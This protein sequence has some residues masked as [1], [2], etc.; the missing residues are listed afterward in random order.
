MN[1]LSSYAHWLHL[2]WPAG[3]PEPLP[4][5]GPD[6]LTAVNGIRIAGDLLGIP[7][8]KFAVDSGAKAVQAFIDEQA[9]K[10][11]CK[12]HPDTYDLAIIGGGVS[13]LS[14][15]LAAHK[16]GLKFVIYEAVEPFATI[17]NFTNGKPIYTYPKTFQPAGDIKL[18][19]TRK[20]ALLAELQQQAVAANIQF[21]LRKVD[22]IV[23]DDKR[24][25]L[26]F[27]DAHG[28]AYAKRVLVC[29]GRNGEHSTLNVP[30]EG[31]AKVHNRLFDPGDYQG[32]KVLVVGGGDSALETAISLCEAGA[33]VTLSYRGSEFS[34]PKPD[35]IVKAQTLLGNAIWFNSQVIEITKD[36]V[37]LSRADSGLEM[38]SNE[39]VFVMIGRKAPI[40]FLKRLG[41]PAR[42]QWSAGKF[43][44]LLLVLLLVALIYSGKSGSG[45]VFS[46][47]FNHSLTP[48]NIDFSRWPDDQAWLRALQPALASCGFYYELAYTLVIGLFGWRRITRTPT[49]YVKRQ[50]LTLFAIQA[51]PLFLLPFVLLPIAGEFG[52]FDSGVAAWLADQLFPYSEQTG[53]REYWRSV[54]FILAWPLFIANVFTEQPNYAW[55]AIGFGQTFVL[56][57]WLVYRYGKGAYCGW[58]CSCGALAETLGDAQRTKMPHGSIWNKLNMAGQA[59][60]AVAILLLLLRIAAWALV[61]SPVGETLADIFTQATYQFKLF[62]IPLNYAEVVDY[63][64]AGILGLGLY[65][66]FSGRTWCRFFCPLAALMH[67]YARFSQFRIFADKDKCISCNICTTVCHQGI[68]VMAFA[69]KGK[70]MEDPQCVRCSACV[71]GCPTGTFNVRTLAF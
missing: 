50:T 17:A 60:L 48:A 6:G 42:G 70:A 44:N 43:A 10:E 2:R 54:G 15:A 31:L 40:D 39:A 64:L 71:S 14:A 69:N 12:N 28:H 33:E 19:A 61:D 22:S 55:L 13:G 37:L 63:F 68:D 53:N 34:R 45:S 57:P 38:L 20:E 23:R 25:A 18:T 30:G 4:E 35:N 36:K 5:T 58:I 46:W 11:P 59:I 41:I 27:N 1:L 56:L 65:F 67:I 16:A 49:P 32:R 66:H 52:A 21:Q 8:L 24:L 29:T 7:L 47:L 3:I 9:F 51:I 26:Q 62:G